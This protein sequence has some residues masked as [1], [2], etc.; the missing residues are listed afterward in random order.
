MSLPQRQ[1]SSKFTGNRSK[2]SGH[3]FNCSNNKQADTFMHTLKR[4]ANHVGA[5]YKH[6]GNI[7]ASIITEAKIA[8]PIPPMPTYQDPKYL[9][10]QEE[11]LKLIFKGQIDS[12]S[13]CTS[14]L[15]DNVQKTYAL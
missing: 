15:E 5:Q 9:T 12:Y 2:I 8:I 1:T 6:G 11:A 3:I 14:A 13:K 7:R 10:P 4:I